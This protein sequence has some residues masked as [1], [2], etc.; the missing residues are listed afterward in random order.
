MADRQ[1]SHRRRAADR[2]PRGATRG[3]LQSPSQAG[4]GPARRPPARVRDRL[5]VR[6]AYGQQVRLRA[7]RALPQVVPGSHPPDDRR[8]VGRFRPAAPGDGREPA[9][10]GAGDRRFSPRADPRWRTGG[11]HPV[12][13]V[14]TRRR[15]PVPGA[16]R[17]QAAGPHLRGRDVVW[18]RT[19]RPPSSWSAKSTGGSSPRTR[20]SST[21]SPACGR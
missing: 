2:D 1:L 14:T 6:G 5:G 20:R 3:I 16:V 10:A 17:V 21:S 13:R 4:R 8:A 7:A 11:S 12:R 19:E 18:R 9:P 15:P